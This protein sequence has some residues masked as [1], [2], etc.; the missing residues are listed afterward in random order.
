M[1]KQVFNCFDKFVVAYPG[2]EI[3][4]KNLSL[5]DLIMLMVNNGLVVGIFVDHNFFGVFFM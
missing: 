1:N 5:A 2:L 3:K 4:Q